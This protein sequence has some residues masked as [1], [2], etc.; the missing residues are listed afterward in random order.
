MKAKVRMRVAACKKR[1]PPLARNF[2][3]LPQVFIGTRQML[4]ES[5]LRILAVTPHGIEKEQDVVHFLHAAVEVDNLNAIERRIP[6]RESFGIRHKG[7]PAFFLERSNK[8]RSHRHSSR[9]SLS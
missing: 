5:Q 2:V 6:G 1:D 9:E 3:E 7:E 8:G 4:C